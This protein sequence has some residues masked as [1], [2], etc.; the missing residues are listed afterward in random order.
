MNE[1]K[2]LAEATKAA[3]LFAQAKVKWVVFPLLEQVAVA[4]I[5]YVGPHSL[6][7]NGKPLMV[8]AIKDAMTQLINCSEDDDRTALMTFVRALLK[9]SGQVFS[10][11]VVASTE[12]SDVSWSPFICGQVEFFAGHPGATAEACLQPRIVPE[13]IALTNMLMKI[14]PHSLL[15]DK[16]LAELLGD[17][18]VLA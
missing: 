11:N 14:I 15:D 8:V 9:Y 7:A 17:N 3:G 4:F 6:A 16:H 5:A 2:L 12:N 1:K 13:M 18:Y 10:Q